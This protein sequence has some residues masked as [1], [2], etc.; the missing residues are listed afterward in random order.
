MHLNPLAAEFVPQSAPR[1]PSRLPPPPATQQRVCSTCQGS[2][3]KKRYSATQWK[4]DDGARRCKDCTAKGIR[5]EREV[6]AKAKKEVRRQLHKANT[7]TTSAKDGGKKSAEK[8]TTR[9]KKQSCLPPIK[10]TEF[11]RVRRNGTITPKDR[12]VKYLELNVIFCIGEM[13]GHSGLLPEIVLSGG[14]DADTHCGDET[15]SSCGPAWYKPT[16]YE[17]WGLP[18]L[19]SYQLCVYG[20]EPGSK[21][22]KVEI[23]SRCVELLAR[24]EEWFV[25]NSD[26]VVPLFD[27]PDFAKRICRGG[28]TTPTRLR[29]QV[30]IRNLNAI[31]GGY[32]AG[33]AADRFYVENLE[34]TGRNELMPLAKTKAYRDRINGTISPKVR[35]I[36]YCELKVIAVV[37]KSGIPSQEELNL[38]PDVPQ[39]ISSYSYWGLSLGGS[40]NKSKAFKKKVRRQCREFLNLDE[41]YFIENFSEI[42]PYLEEVAAMGIS[43]SGE[44]KWDGHIDE[45]KQDVAV[46]VDDDELIEI[47]QSEILGDYDYL[48]NPFS[49]IGQI[50]AP[51]EH[52]VHDYG[53][54]IWSRPDRLQQTAAYRMR[55]RGQIDAKSRLLQYCE[56]RSLRNEDE[57]EAER[58]DFRLPV[59]VT[60]NRYWGIA[61]D[62]QPACFERDREA[63]SYFIGVEDA[64][65]V[66]DYDKIRPLFRDIAL[67]YPAEVGLIETKRL[68]RLR[69]FVNFAVSQAWI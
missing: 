62:P 59:R 10:S 37:E 58:L 5:D 11:S 61:P 14:D 4:K 23:R 25:A 42:E 35:L 31:I 26:K 32:A 56:L 52:E 41:E 3:P 51:H 22:K 46:E 44:V 34:D 8:E 43:H 7:K 28:M 69:K 36:T 20:I 13:E 9:K 30:F 63:W 15:C 54:A 67:I 17:Y 47:L 2:Y 64:W 27:D 45:I 21:A 16:K 65:I 49:I 39:V 53:P 29:W 66:R 12:L 50:L 60:N 38:S 19:G 1:L 6:T 40:R 55:M 57:F 18:R 48:L 33:K 24:E 68:E